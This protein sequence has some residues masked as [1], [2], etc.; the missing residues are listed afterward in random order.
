MA[1]ITDIL[2]NATHPTDANIRNQALQLIEKAKEGKIEDFIGILMGELGDETKPEQSRQQAGLLLKNFMVSRNVVQREE[3]ANRWKN[4][5]ADVRESVKQV[6]MQTMSS[7]TKKAREVSS[8]I[9][10]VIFRVEVPHNQWPDLI[11][12]LCKGATPQTANSH[13]RES[14]ILCLKYICE[15]VSYKHLTQSAIDIAKC[16]VNGC[17]E[18]DMNVKRESITALCAAF[19]IMGPVMELEP[20]RAYL[21][22]VVLGSAQNAQLPL[23]IRE[24]AMS[25]LVKAVSL[26]YP[27]LKNEM[28]DVY[29][30]TEMILAG[31][32]ETLKCTALELWSAMCEVEQDILDDPSPTKAECMHYVK[33]AAKMLIPHIWMGLLSQDED[34]EENDWNFC[35]ASGHALQTIST[36][37]CDDV[38]ALVFPY[39]EKHLHSQEWKYRDA[40]VMAFGSVLDGPSFDTVQN[41]LPQVLATLFDMVDQNQTQPLHPLFLETIVWTLGRFA[42]FKYQLILNDEQLTRRFL[43]GMM[44]GATQYP[45]R[46]AEK[47]CFAIHGLAENAPTGDDEELQANQLTAYFHDLLNALIAAVDREDG[48]GTQLPLSAL[49]TINSLLST[50]A[51]ESRQ[52]LVSLFPMLTGRLE[53]SIAIYRDAVT[54]DA[55][56]QV[57]LDLLPHHPIRHS[58]S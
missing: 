15:E 28:N 38:V 9:A 25:C 44:I 16:L 18:N 35:F 50:S 51:L 22:K 55:K 54:S 42:E 19:E 43:T 5:S 40:A 49:E 37:I 3:I 31:G 12:N 57:Y 24:E 11:P 56:E 2:I 21:M 8:L 48:R 41:V 20:L 45:P 27:N 53:H 23:E 46:I 7:P 32:E 33:G 29:T 52:H 30:V 13:Q 36:I 6:T 1:S 4:V 34:A 47:A 10:A 14:C 26:Y 58:L 17:E 39:V